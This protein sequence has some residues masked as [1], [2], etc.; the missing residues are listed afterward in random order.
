MRKNIN[1]KDT[2]SDYILSSREC[3]ARALEMHY[4][5]S[6][7]GKDALSGHTYGEADKIMPYITQDNYVSY[8]T[9]EIKIKP[10]I[11]QFLS[12]NQDVFGKKPESG[13]SDPINVPNDDDLQKQ[14]VLENE[15]A[16]AL[17]EL[18]LGD[19]KMRRGGQISNTTM[20]L[21]TKLDF[22]NA[23]KAIKKIR[24]DETNK[25]LLNKEIFVV[26]AKNNDGFKKLLS[27]NIKSKEYIDN[28][29]KKIYLVIDKNNKE[30]ALCINGIEEADKPMGFLVPVLRFN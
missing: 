27:Q 30:K 15:T 10:K 16:L 22:K 24:K 1:K 21:K 20:R 17:L 29:T 2:T 28:K 19:D 14:L 26:T 25:I 13:Q 9:Y 18:E 7:E 8:E 3:F 11:E 6:K 12:E 4:A 23:N 5:I